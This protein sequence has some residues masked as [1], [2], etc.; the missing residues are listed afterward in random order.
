VAS[1][2][3]QAENSPRSGLRPFFAGDQYLGSR[4]TLGPWAATASAA[5]APWLVLTFAFGSF[6]FT[7]HVTDVAGNRMLKTARGVVVIK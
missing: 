5:S 3:R 2:P 4:V 1:T 6:R 7:V